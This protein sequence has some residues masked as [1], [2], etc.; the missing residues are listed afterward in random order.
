MR[1]G[2]AKLAINNN[3]KLKNNLRSSNERRKIK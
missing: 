2:L 3:K 1:G